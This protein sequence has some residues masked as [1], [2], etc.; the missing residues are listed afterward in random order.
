MYV[1]LVKDNMRELLKFKAV[2]C[3]PCKSLSNIMED[4]DFGVP[5]REVDID[6][7]T[8][9]TVKYNI[10]NVP[11]LVLV[12]DGVEVKRMSGAQSVDRIKQWLD[13]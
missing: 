7:D 12:E 10:R 13:N 6:D 5:V 4:V 11:T 9:T 1:W 8:E 3:G 2:W